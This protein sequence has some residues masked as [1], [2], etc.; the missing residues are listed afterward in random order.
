MEELRIDKKY[1]IKENETEVLESKKLLINRDFFVKGSLEIKNCEIYLEEPESKCYF[2]LDEGSQL[3]ISDSKI[4]SSNN[5]EEIII[6]S[7]EKSQILFSNCSF[8][9]CQNL[10]VC[11]D[12]FAEIEEII[13][14]NS[15]FENCTE[16]INV[17]KVNNIEISNSEFSNCKHTIKAFEILGLATI[18]ECKIR[19]NINYFLRASAED[20]G[21]LIEACDFKGWQIDNVILRSI[22]EKDFEIITD[23]KYLEGGIAEEYY[24]KIKSTGDII[25]SDDISD[26]FESD[27]DEIANLYPLKIETVKIINSHFDGNDEDFKFQLLEAESCLI[28]NSTFDNWHSLGKKKLSPDGIFVLSSRYDETL[29]Q[30]IEKSILDLLD[31]QDDTPEKEFS[32]TKLIE[33]MIFS[34]MIYSENCILKHC[35]FKNTTGISAVDA[36]ILHTTFSNGIGAAVAAD[37]LEMKNSIVKDFSVQNRSI[38]WTGEELILKN[39]DFVDCK[40]LYRFFFPHFGRAIIELDEDYDSSISGCTFKNCTATT[41]IDEVDEDIVTI[42]NCKEIDCKYI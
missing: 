17:A 21:V 4:F 20:E 25:K 7:N 15:T 26:S 14:N 16:V 5:N 39:S 19:D 33:T 18:R 38:V 9:S 31:L 30:K 6:Y 13:I 40:V 10:I 41:M 28:E 27:E 23:F 1:L 29:K 12:L 42:K 2:Y 36:E 11:D 3:S 37:N 34:E 32:F 22:L 35:D 24:F 8:S